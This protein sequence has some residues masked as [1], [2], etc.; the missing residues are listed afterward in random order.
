MYIVVLLA[1][2]GLAVG[3]ISMTLSKSKAFRSA[4]KAVRDR[5]KWLGDLASCPYC[6]SHWVSAGFALFL[7]PEITGSPIADF[8]LAM[9][10]TVTLSAVSC[11]LIFKAFSEM[12]ADP[13][14]EEDQT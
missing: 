1:I 4:R 6:T 7:R 13:Q 2:L 10:A 8:V 9:F 11:G 14:T 5:S 12:P 3:S